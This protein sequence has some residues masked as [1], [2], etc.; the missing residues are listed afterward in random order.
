MIHARLDCSRRLLLGAGAALAAGLGLSDKGKAMEVQ[1]TPVSGYAE[2][3]GLKVYYELHGGAPASGKIPL[4]M[5]PGGATSIATTFAKDLLPRFA[6]VWPVIAIEPQGHGH[7]DDRPGPISVEQMAKDVV[8]V[9]DHLK[10]PKAHL[11]GHSLGGMI[12]TGVAVAA[13]DRVASATIVGA[14]YTLEGMLP[15]LVKMQ[16]D[17]SHVPSAEL[18]PLLP[19]QEDFAAWTA[20]YQ[21]VNPHPENFQKVLGKLNVTLTE[22]KGWTPAQLGAIRAPTLLAIGDND[23]TRI[24][25]AAEMKRLIPG[26]QLAVLPGTTHM[27]IIERGDWLE[28]MMRARMA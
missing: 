20:H 28:P 16:R 1:K 12:A 22:W 7:T 21:K 18:I 27:N 17:P 26:S 24:E 2:T 5:L 19:T 14:T 9:L 25:H 4:V 3:D 8:A 11:F 15:E 13:P 23:F 10:V 6:K